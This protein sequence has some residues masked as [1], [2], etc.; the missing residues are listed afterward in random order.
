M[1]VLRLAGGGD[2]PRSFLRGK[3]ACAV[4]L[5]AAS[6]PCSAKLPIP[7]FEVS[8]FAYN[9][10]VPVAD[11]LHEWRGPLKSGADGITRNIALV[12][13]GYGAWHL[14]Y[15]Y[16]YDYEIKASRDSAELYFDVTNKNPLVIGREYALDLRVF[17]QRTQGLRLAHDWR[18]ETWSITLGLTALDGLA[19]TQGHLS[20]T[21]VAVGEREYQYQANVGYGYSIESLFERRVSMPDGLGFS[22]DL[23]LHWRPLPLLSADLRVDD[24]W[25]ALWWHH[26]PFTQATA[27]S[28]TARFDEDGYVVYDPVLTGEE[29]VRNLRQRLH[30]RALLDL[31]WRAGPREE[32]GFGLDASE[33]KLIPALAWRHRLGEGECMSIGVRAL[34]V[35]SALGVEAQFGDLKLSVA[36]DAPAIRDAHYLELLLSIGRSF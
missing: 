18:A 1:T 19:L 31:R 28:Q 14:G 7:E 13:A 23:R 3:L 33:V 8:A 17:N 25:G 12:G 24:L 10:P 5:I 34:P 29:T 35:E 32:F 4:L 20:G 16:R 22:T 15:V 2:A 21:A 36:S 9:E 30:P 26:A 11:Y 6:A 27:N